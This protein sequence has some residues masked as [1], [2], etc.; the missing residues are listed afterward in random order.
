MKVIE[1]EW[2]DAFSDDGL[3]LLSDYI[4]TNF[5]MVRSNI[6]YFVH[7]DD[8]YY[9]LAAHFVPQRKGKCYSGYFAIPKVCVRQLKVLR[10]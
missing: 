6:G 7:E 8:D 1:I 4:D 3:L 10:K 2:I 9:Y 5:P